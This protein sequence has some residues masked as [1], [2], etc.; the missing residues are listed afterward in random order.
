MFALRC[1]D[2]AKPNIEAV[3]NTGN[4]PLGA[5]CSS[6]AYPRPRRGAFDCTARNISDTEAALEVSIFKCLD[7]MPK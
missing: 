7:A 6:P 1:F 5:A 4:W 2:F 3:L